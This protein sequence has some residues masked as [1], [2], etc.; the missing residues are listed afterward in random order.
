MLVRGEFFLLKKIVIIN[1]VFKKKLSIVLILENID[2]L[3]MVL[4]VMKIVF[5]WGI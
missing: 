2:F 5:F 4:F 3:N 1:E